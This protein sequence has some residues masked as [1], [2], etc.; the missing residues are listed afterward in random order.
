MRRRTVLATV[1]TSVLGGCGEL[2]GESDS[3]ED[4]NGDDEAEDDD[5]QLQ[6]EPAKQGT[7][8]SNV[9][10]ATDLDDG[11]TGKSAT[12]TLAGG[13]YADFAFTTGEESE[14][15]MTGQVTKNGPIDF[16]VMTPDQFNRYQREPD[17][18]DAE[19]RGEN[20]DSIDLDRQLQSGEYLFVFDNTYLG[21][22]DPSGKVEIE[23]EF[24][25]GP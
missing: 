13:E 5:A 24:V 12:L 18:I 16:Y 4:E 2:T 25:L 7:A 9:R 3:D 15:D 10:T 14:M 17:G 23:F 11:E 8:F 6:F 20:V 22:A 21:G 19:A 1:A